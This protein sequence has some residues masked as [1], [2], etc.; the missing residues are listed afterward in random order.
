MTGR[1]RV[2]G[3]RIG[4]SVKQSTSADAEQI[5]ENST[6][7]KNVEQSNTASDNLVVRGLG[8]ARGKFAIIALVIL[9]IAYAFYIYSKR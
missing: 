7:H 4:G 6:I 8:S 1:Q 2:T 9:G 5:V 3:S